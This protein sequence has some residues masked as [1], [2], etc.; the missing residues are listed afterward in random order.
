VV[1]DAH[2]ST[3]L[4]GSWKVFHRTMDRLRTAVAD[5][6]DRAV[7]AVVFA[8][9]LTENG[10]REDFEAVHDV[11]REL[12][13]PSMAIPGNH[14]VPK[15]FDEDDVP[16]LAEFEAMFS[17]AGLPFAERVGGVDLVGLNTAS[18]PDGSL[19]DTHDG[20]VSPDQTAW[21]DGVLA[22]A[23]APLVVMHHNL[24]GLL[25][26]TGGHSWRS[27]F[28]IRNHEPLVDVLASNDAPL[29]VS[30]HLHL[31]AVTETAGVT[32]LVSP[33]LS[34]FPQGYLLV[35]VDETGTTVRYV[36]VADTAGVREAYDHAQR[37]TT[38]SSAV[39]RL[40]AAQ[41][42]K[43]PLVDELAGAERSISSML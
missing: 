33:A 14:D 34:T 22:D 21:L 5:L 20:E 40:T 1:A 15:T 16:T 18:T 27:S 7:D 24:P 10:A 3:R 38:R 11:V 43:L 19:A 29:V 13:P 31:P 26:R 30:A 23:D 2:V 25:A 9:D 35:E 28:P 36:P 12:E 6:N 17:P 42:S 4:D 37:H 41:F 32:E 39:A 8:G